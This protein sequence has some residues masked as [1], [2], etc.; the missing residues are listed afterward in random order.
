MEAFQNAAF[1]PNHQYFAALTLSV[2][3][4]RLRVW[5]TASHQLINDFTGQEGDECISLSW[6][7]LILALGLKSGTIDLFSIAQKSII[8]SLK[9]GHKS[10]VNDFAFDGVRG[11]SISEDG[12]VCEWDLETL[13]CIR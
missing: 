13:K 6:S 7:D 4:Y 5:E 12:S 1:S 2:N 3:A 11:Y 8:G 9:N 10:M